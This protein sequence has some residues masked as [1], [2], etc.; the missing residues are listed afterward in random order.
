[1][2]AETR[3][4]MEVISTQFTNDDPLCL[5]P[6]YD[7]SLKDRIRVSVLATFEQ[8]FRDF[9]QYSHTASSMMVPTD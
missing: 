9:A 3:T 7:A 6:I 8:S 5:R 4:I 1:M 2:L